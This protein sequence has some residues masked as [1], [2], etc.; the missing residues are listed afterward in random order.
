MGLIRNYDSLALN[1]ERKVVLSLIEAALSS[2]QPKQVLEH[3]FVIEKNSLTI[4]NEKFDLSSYDRIFLLG[5][6]KGSSGI[7]KIIEEKLGEKLTLGFD[8]DLVD[9]T[10]QKVKYTKGTHP[11]PSQTNFYFTKNALDAIG[12]TTEKDL[13][14]VVIC[15]GGS[16][17]FETPYKV[18]IEKLTQVVDALLKSGADITE[19]NVIR[20]HLS[21]VKGGGL[22]KLL[23]PASVA[24]LIF[25]DVPG[26]NLSTI[27]SGPTVKD[28]ST[29]QDA[30]NILE[31]YQIHQKVELSD[32]DFTETG[33]EDK[34]FEKVKNILIISNLTALSAM[35]QKAKEMGFKTLTTTDRLQGDARVM[36]KQLID[37][38]TAGEILLAGGETTIKVKGTG[39]GGRNQALV[40]SALLY[41]GNNTVLASF[42]SDGWDFYGF[43]GAIGDKETLRKAKEL[44]LDYKTFLDDDNSYEFFSK[45]GDG[46]DTGKLESN[47]ADLY[48]VLKK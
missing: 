45:E 25:S 39:K 46:I 29:L 27:A 5:F 8:I 9:E 4:K 2:V 12:Q 17:M 37:Q 3:E 31:K 1:D 41:L 18:S 36:G 11:L 32:D 22:A 24:S 19:M 21:R 15:G 38:A 28:A 34:Y 30:A 26:N 44:Q 16:V 20:K 43:A 14:L 48:I 10:F 47:V 7:C 42:G 6:G 23:Y 13:V 35:E 40:L 33:R